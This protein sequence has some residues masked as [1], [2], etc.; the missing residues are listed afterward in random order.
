M[1]SISQRKNGLKGRDYR[2]KYFDGP[3]LAENREK[4]L[5][6]NPNIV[7]FNT[8]VLISNNSYVHIIE[9]SKPNKNNEEK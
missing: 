9:Y 7:I 4:F 1:E 2:V 6:E 5:N 8:H 3:K